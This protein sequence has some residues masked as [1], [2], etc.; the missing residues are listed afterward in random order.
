MRLSQRQPKDREPRTSAPYPPA[1]RPAARRW[2]TCLPMT[3][4]DRRPQSLPV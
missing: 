4:L 1:E 2:P 3:L